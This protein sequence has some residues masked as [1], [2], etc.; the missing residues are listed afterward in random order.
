M[1]QV[2]EAE[3]D[4]RRLL[5]MT[6]RTWGNEPLD[7]SSITRTWSLDLGWL[8]P[9]DAEI[10]LTKLLAKGWLVSKDDRLSTNTELD[11][12]SVPLGWF[13][14]TTVLEQPPNCPQGNAEIKNSSKSDNNISQEKDR[15]Y[16][17]DNESNTPVSKSIIVNT[18]QQS[19]NVPALLQLISK[20]SN[21]AR[22]EVMRRAQRKRKSLGHIT[23]WMALI[24]VAREL[25]VDI[26]NLIPS[27][28]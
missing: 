7:A 4:I 20:E 2:S 25:Q 1:S 22:Q 9:T 13:P 3:H 11:N 19:F 28:E 16:K 14:R 26:E 27:D 5:A 21:L 8:A 15:I 6:W 12:V 18:G 17:T 23:A 24:L 10:L